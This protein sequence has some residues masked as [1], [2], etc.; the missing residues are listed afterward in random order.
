MAASDW[1]D[2]ITWHAT[3]QPRGR[4]TTS[5]PLP[6]CRSMVVNGGSGQRWSTA[7]VNGGQRRTESLDSIFNRL[8][9]IISQLAI[10]DENISQEDL[11][12]KF[13]RSLPAEWNTHVVVWRN[14]PN[15]DT[16]P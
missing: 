16:T 14:K 5:Q 12:L 6:D 10:L 15:L 7:A 1:P 11:N 4:S 8:Q 9:K 13:L 2:A 3:W